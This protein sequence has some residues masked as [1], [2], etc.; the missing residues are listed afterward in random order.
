MATFDWTSDDLYANSCDLE[1]VSLQIFL[2]FANVDESRS[3]KLAGRCDVYCIS[4]MSGV[5]LVLQFIEGPIE[6]LCS[7]GNNIWLLPSAK[8][9]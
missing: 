4:I 2:F 9:G 8:S 7:V 5:S 3:V 1:G 6:T